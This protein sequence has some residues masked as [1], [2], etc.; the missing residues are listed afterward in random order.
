MV[1]KCCPA[2]SGIGSYYGTRWVRDESV[3][4]RCR[5][6]TLRKECELCA[7]PGRRAEGRMLR[8]KNPP[9]AVEEALPAVAPET[10]GIGNVD[11][12]VGWA[13]CATLFSYVAFRLPQEPFVLLGWQSLGAGLLA[14]LVLLWSVE[15]I[16]V[17]GRGSRRV[18][19]VGYLLAIS[20][21]LI[22]EFALP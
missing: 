14:A 18:A 3:E 7:R 19:L 20:G 6:V 15:K 16:S 22:F 5:P 8:V 9:V 10:S 11:R 13:L 2:C 12:F 21:G 17:N 1:K 4:L